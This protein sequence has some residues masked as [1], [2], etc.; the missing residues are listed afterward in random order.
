MNKE[1]EKYILKLNTIGYG[2][3]DVCDLCGNDLPILK[4]DPYKEIEYKNYLEYNGVQILCK[5]C[6]E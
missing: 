3:I 2:K 1:K 5:K 4:Y 6:R